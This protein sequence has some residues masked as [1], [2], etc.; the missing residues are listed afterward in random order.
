[1]IPIQTLKKVIAM[2]SQT[3]Q[4]I[5]KRQ[6]KSTD[7][8][9]TAKQVGFGV[10][11]VG[12]AYFVGKKILKD[13][14]KNRSELSFSTESQQAIALRGAM[15]RSGMSWLHWM[16]GT[17][18][19]ALYSLANDI[20]NIQKV[21]KEYKNLYNRVLAEDLRKELATDELEKFN[22]LVNKQVQVINTA[23]TSTLPTNQTNAFNNGIKGSV[24]LIEEPVRIFKSLTWIPFGS[25]K[26]AEAKTYIPY[27]VTRLTSTS[28]T[29]FQKVEFYEV[30]IKTIENKAY[31]I[32]VGKEDTKLIQPD[33]LIN[34]NREY[35][36]LSFTNEDFE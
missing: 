27:P 33:E 12:A 36:L 20:N 24:V 23:S 5:K 22:S 3:T 4:D 8:A 13:T 14:K 28:I 19:D 16:D 21:A 31:T 26:K 34:Y 10:L 2:N 35:K 7:L 9:R 30:L 15:N 11:A 18:T 25:I 1:M 6:E 17:N 29:L 32:Y